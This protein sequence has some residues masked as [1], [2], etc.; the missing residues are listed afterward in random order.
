MVQKLDYHFWYND[1]LSFF[2]LVDFSGYP[3]GG[4]LLIYGI[5]KVTHNMDLTF[6]VY[7]V[8]C[9]LIG[10]IT[11]FNFFNKISRDEYLA[12][13][14]SIFYMTLPIFISYTW[15]SLTLRGLLFALLPL[16]FSSLV[17]IMNNHKQK[18]FIVYNLGILILLNLIHRSSMLLIGISLFIIILKYQPIIT[19][20]NFNENFIENRRFS[21][22]V[23]YILLSLIVYSSTFIFPIN[24]SE[25]VL[26]Y[27][28]VSKGFSAFLAIFV[29]LFF[30]FGMVLF[31]IAYQQIVA[32]KYTVNKKAEINSLQLFFYL[33][34]AFMS[35]VLIYTYYLS[36]FIII[37]L[38]SLSILQVDL[39]IHNEKSVLLFIGTM[40]TIFIILY[41]TV[42][43]FTVLL[44]PMAIILIGASKYFTNHV[45]RQ[46]IKKILVFLLLLNLSFSFFYSIN[47]I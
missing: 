12:T 18:K 36:A 21:F 44:F 25:L 20:N 28:K 23:Y 42:L 7:G 3:A 38:L 43:N 39:I 6:F 47:R 41:S 19:Y 24:P 10:S 46:N 31:A 17:N 32:I 35:P 15:M 14:Y 2:G 45:N 5:N 11:S 29:D 9:T 26:P 37:P 13:L 16:Y 8:L 27:I 34:I 33:L 40:A 30:R 4:I 1:I 22:V